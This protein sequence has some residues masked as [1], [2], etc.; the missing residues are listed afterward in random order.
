MTTPD[1]TRARIKRALI[2]IADE[3]KG[4][5]DPLLAFVAREQLIL[6]R[7]Y[8]TQMMHQLDEGLVPPRDQRDYGMADT[9]ISDWPFTTLGEAIVKAERAWRDLDAPEGPAG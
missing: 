2:M 8:L 3:L 4:Q 1:E 9:V 5:A 7:G 6:W